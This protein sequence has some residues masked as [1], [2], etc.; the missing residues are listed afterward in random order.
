MNLK[1]S[2]KLIASRYALVIFFLI[3]FFLPT[4]SKS[5]LPNQKVLAIREISLENRQPDKWVNGIFEDNI[6][7]TLAYARDKIK[8]PT[9]IDWNEI[10]KPF[11]YSITLSP[12][13]LFAFHE[14]VLAE[15]KNKTV[16]TTKAHFNYQEGFK[17]DG[18]LVGDGVCHLA[19]LIYWAAQDAKL[20]VKAP[21]NHD[22]AHI[23]G[24]PKK[25]GVSIFY[26]LG[27]NF[28][29]ALQNIYL[30]NNREKPIDIQFI[31]NEE[32]LKVAIVEKT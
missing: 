17:Y 5:S 22:F 23:E 6:L 32:K 11:T 15:Y 20:Q 2:H 30:T 24:V 9:S 13:E 4:F 12:G 7:L 25:Y 21:T 10:K 26:M 31:Y 18:F 29:N 3:I 28:A 16:I 1:K 27:S 14:D 19:S 8:N